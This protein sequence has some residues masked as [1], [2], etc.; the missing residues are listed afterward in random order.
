MWHTRM[1]L[2]HF[3]DDNCTLKRRISD[4]DV[5]FEASNI[6]A[7]TWSSC[8]PPAFPALSDSQ[9]VFFRKCTDTGSV[10]ESH[11]GLFPS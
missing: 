6:Y 9:C 1:S 5:L 10:Y 3:P 2:L 7:L 11:S 8:E 4:S